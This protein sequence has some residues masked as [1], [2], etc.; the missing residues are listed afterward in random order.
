MIPLLLPDFHSFHSWAPKLPIPEPW[1]SAGDWWIHWINPWIRMPHSQV[2]DENEGMSRWVRS[3]FLLCLGHVQSLGLKD[4]QLSCPVAGSSFLGALLKPR[5]FICKVQ[6]LWMPLEHGIEAPGTRLNLT[7]AIWILCHGFVKPKQTNTLGTH[8]PS[9]Q[10]KCRKATNA[11]QNNLDFP[12][13][14]THDYQQL[15]PSLLSTLTPKESM[16]RSRT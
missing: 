3:D 4:P 14:A 11:P 9:S 1:T 8:I 16:E 2:Q 7:Q 15:L 13:Q 6:S 5:F 10:E 12:R